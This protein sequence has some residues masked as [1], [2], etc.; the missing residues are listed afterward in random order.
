MSVA[1]HRV[2]CRLRNLHSR[3]AHERVYEP[4]PCR[5]FKHQSVLLRRLGNADIRLQKNKVINLTLAAQAIDGIVIRPGETFS[6]WSAVGNPT[7]KRGFVSGMLLSSGEVKEG[8]GG[9]LCQMANLL[10]WMALHTDLQI[11]ER[12]HHSLDIFPDS[13]R[14]VPFGTGCAV[15]YNYV[16]LQFT[17]PTDQTY[18]FRIWI[19]DEHLKGEIRSSQESKVSY[20]IIERDHRFV[21]EVDGVYRENAIY[22]QAFDKRTGDMIEDRLLYTNHSKV[23]YPVADEQITV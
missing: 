23:L 20:S 1:V 16:D 21:R 9:G 2:I 4:L 5:V 3:F 8:I 12:H 11:I 18:Q 19:T 13:G 17:N 15:F 7:E 14:A 6:F 10:Y 22:R